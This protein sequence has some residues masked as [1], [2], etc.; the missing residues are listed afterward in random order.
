MTPERKLQIITGLRSLIT[1]IKDVT[2]A[3]QLLGS[4]PVKT[5]FESLEKEGPMDRES[6]D[7]LILLVCATGFVKR[8]GLI[9]RR[10]TEAERKAAA[11]STLEEM[12]ALQAEIEQRREEAEKRG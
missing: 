3:V 10:A 2:K 5:L 11:E 9:L 8:D 6:F 4:I 12:R 7:R 1:L